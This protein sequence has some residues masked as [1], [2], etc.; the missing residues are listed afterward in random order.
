VFK[1]LQ[2]LCVREHFTKRILCGICSTWHISGTTRIS[3]P[4]ISRVILLKMLVWCLHNV[5]AS[6][7]PPIED[8]TVWWICA[9]PIE[10]D[11][12]GR[13]LD[14]VY[15]DCD[16]TSQYKLGRI[17]RHDVVVAGLPAGCIG[18]SSALERRY[19]PAFQISKSKV[20]PDGWRWWWSSKW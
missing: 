4:Y 11:A 20:W 13:I 12:A 8:F 7:R 14:A 17:G 10:F 1:S 18:L 19:G 15:E 6:R 5:H 3:P 2:L 9:L 16:D